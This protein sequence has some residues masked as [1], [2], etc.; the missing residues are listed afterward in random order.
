MLQ[1]KLKLNK[2][3]QN[4]FGFVDKLDSYKKIFVRF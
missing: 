3:N 2:S 1:K 4:D